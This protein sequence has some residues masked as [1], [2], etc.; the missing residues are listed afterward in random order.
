MTAV[1]SEVWSS[2]APADSIPATA[3]TS[4]TINAHSSS[5]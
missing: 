2:H 4:N 1:T 3:I 5:W